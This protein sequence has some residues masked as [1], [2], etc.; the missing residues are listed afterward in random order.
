M[1]RRGLLEKSAPDLDEVRGQIEHWRKTRPSRGTMPRELW[2]AAATLA[3]SH[4]IYAVSQHL[5]ISYDSLK[6]HVEG[7]T[8]PKAK[9]LKKPLSPE[10]VELGPVLPQR[11][12]VDATVMELV[13]ASGS[14]LIVRM[15]GAAGADVVALIRELYNRAP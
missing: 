11:P 10:F 14:R 7:A 12:V 8:L 1:G 13:G 5:H 3:R 2:E 15:S 9:A 4:G 6:T